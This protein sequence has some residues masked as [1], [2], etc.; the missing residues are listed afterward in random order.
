MALFGGCVVPMFLKERL[1]SAPWGPWRQLF[2]PSFGQRAVHPGPFLQAWELRGCGLEAGGWDWQ[3]QV[4]QPEALLWLRRQAET[5]LPPA[6]LGPHSVFSVLPGSPV[7]TQRWQTPAW[8]LRQR[9]VGSVAQSHPVGS[10]AQSHP[11]G[12]GW[13]L[14]ARGCGCH[15]PRIALD[16]G[17][18]GG[19]TQL[20]S[21]CLRTAGIY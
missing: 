18:S 20:V 1:G 4:S 16:P 2:A 5:P 8:P 21:V 13:R 15:V 7:S 9:P 3:G 12:S 10:V 19:A 14:A 11:A 6:C 17:V